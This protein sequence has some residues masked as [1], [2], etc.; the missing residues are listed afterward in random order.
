VKRIKPAAFA[1]YDLNAEAYTS[2]LW[3]FE[4]FTSYYDDLMLV[5][6]GVIDEAAYFKLFAK[7]INGVLRGS[8]RHKQSVAESS[9]DAWTKYYRQDE[10]SPNAIVS[11]YTKGSLVA[12]TLDLTIRAET[13]GKKSLDHVMRTL[14]QRYGRDFYSD[15]DNG[16]GVTEAEVEALFDEVTGLK[17]KRLLDRC[18][19]GTA[20]LPLAEVLAP[21]GV[22]LEDQRKNA[23]PSLNVRTTRDGNDCKLT[24]V[25]EGGAA[26]RAGLSAGDVLVAVDSL[27][28]TATNLDTLLARYRVGESVMLHAF[29]RDELMAFV[30]K[31]AADDVP[32]MRLTV[33]EK[34]AVP[35]KMRKAWLL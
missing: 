10:N 34:L 24:S 23:K 28:V 3:L 7:T 2:L 5:R 26:H 33:Q 27:R 9:F 19:R 16:R 14:W 1:P 15:A 31:F 6:S 8:G 4:G 13:K 22:T 17:L 21:F 11:Y 32:Q 25:Y 18:V 12:L 35:S 30:V 29:R 20:D